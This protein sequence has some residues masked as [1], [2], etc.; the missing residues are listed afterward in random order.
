MKKVGLIIGFGS[1][2]KKHFKSMSKSKIFKKIYILSKRLNRNKNYIDNLSQISEINPDII[3]ICSETSSHLSQLMYI[4]KNF[5]NKIILV[6]KPLFSKSSLFKIKNNKVFVAYNLRYD[7]ILQY[8]KK[9]AA[10]MKIICTNINCNSFLPNWRNRNYKK[11]YSASK[12]KGGGVHLDL[13]HEIDYANWIF[14]SLKRK[15]ITLKKISNLRINSYDYTNFSGTSYLSKIVNI[16]LNY[17][18]RMEKRNIEI[19]TNKKYLFIDIINRIIQFKSS[20]DLKIKKF[21]KINA[22]QRMEMQIKDISRRKPIY[23]CT[24]NEALEILKII[25]V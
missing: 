3:V 6:E 17:F 9:Y 13:S 16:N 19:F 24:Y 11:L 1:I 14:K 2:G 12:K 23:A 4:E 7:P 8:I 18:S 21:K 10:N 15:S 20:K 22:L 5:Y 25:G